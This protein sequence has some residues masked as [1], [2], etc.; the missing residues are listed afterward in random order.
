MQPIL[1]I[2]RAWILDESTLLGPYD[3]DRQSTVF[4]SYKL[5]DSG[6]RWVWAKSGS[7]TIVI[8]PTVSGGKQFAAVRARGE[9]AHSEKSDI[10][11]TFAISVDVLSG[12]IVF[13]PGVRNDSNGR[14]TQ[15]GIRQIVFYN[16]GTA[17]K[18]V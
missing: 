13:S 18:E 9:Y 15:G 10:E 11:M 4:A 6:D 5:T 16:D 8:V 12:E 14:I 3:I 2:M 7:V 1:R 17:H